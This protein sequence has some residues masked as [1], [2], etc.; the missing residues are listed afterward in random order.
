MWKVEKVTSSHGGVSETRVLVCSLSEKAAICIDF[1]VRSITRTDAA[2]RTIGKV[3]LSA[4]GGSERSL[5]CQ[6]HGF[7]QVLCVSVSMGGIEL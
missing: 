1:T 7:L 3:P 5:L 2:D 6:L 4:V